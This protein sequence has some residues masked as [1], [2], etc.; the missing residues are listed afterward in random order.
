M[1]RVPMV[2]SAAR[3]TARLLRQARVETD[4]AGE[5]PVVGAH[6]AKHTR[7]V[8]EHILATRLACQAGRAVIA[9][10]VTFAVA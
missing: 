1:T 6:R 10:S 4:A 8:D 2:C 5:L 9:S 7:V 3:N